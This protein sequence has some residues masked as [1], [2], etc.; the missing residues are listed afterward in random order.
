MMYSQNFYHFFQQSANDNSIL[1]ASIGDPTGQLQISCFG[2]GVTATDRESE[3]SPVTP[4]N[5]AKNYVFW[6]RIADHTLD[7]GNSVTGI[8]PRSPEARLIASGDNDHPSKDT[9]FL[10]DSDGRLVNAQ[11]VDV[12]YGGEYKCTYMGGTTNEEYTHKVYVQG[13]DPV[14]HSEIM[15]YFLIAGVALCLLFLFCCVCCCLCKRK[16]KQKKA[17]DLQKEIEKV[18]IQKEGESPSRIASPN[19][20][21]S[22][23]QY[24]PATNFIDT[25]GKLGFL[26][27]NATIQRGTYQRASYNQD[28]QNGLLQNGLLQKSPYHG[29]HYTNHN[30]NEGYQTLGHHGYHTI[31]TQN[32]Y[33]FQEPSVGSSGI[34][35]K[36]S[37]C[38]VNSD[39]NSSSSSTKPKLQI[40]DENSN[41][42]RAV[43]NQMYGNSFGT[44]RKMSQTSSG[45]VDTKVKLDV[46]TVVE[47]TITVFSTRGN[48]VS[49]SHSNGNNSHGNNSN[50]NNSSNSNQQHTVLSVMTSPRVNSNSSQTT[51]SSHIQVG[52]GRVASGRTLKPPKQIKSVSH[53]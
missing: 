37:I 24:Q 15:I 53:I 21:H 9:N 41:T 11:D 26:G 1:T 51:S 43:T 17:L 23:I 50:G 36:I 44:V 48:N 40:I 18:L 46:K 12:N 8:A 5:I 6:Y 29:S 19:V 22:I 10:V 16:K 14:G 42:L 52:R 45:F 39:S 27:S 33:P 25:E 35:K 32:M 28:E 7:I 30:E 20:G 34:S 47:P 31:N 13:I 3:F 4:S 49:G 2:T 38:A